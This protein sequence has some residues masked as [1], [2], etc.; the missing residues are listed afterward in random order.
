MA[1]FLCR[2]TYF[3][4]TDIM[5]K[6]LRKNCILCVCLKMKTHPHGHSREEQDDK[7]RNYGRLARRRLN[8]IVNEAADD[9]DD[10]EDDN[11]DVDSVVEV[12]VS[13]EVFLDLD[14]SR[15]NNDNDNSPG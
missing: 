8:D 11:I 10:D 4:D 9:P 14:G 2:Y 3:L 7:W 5:N 15:W 12:E 1:N 6:Q 13:I